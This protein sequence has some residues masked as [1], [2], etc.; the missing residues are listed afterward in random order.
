M[1]AMSP[2][3]HHKP[4]EPPVKQA[5]EIF[6]FQAAKSLLRL[7]TTNWEQ[8]LDVLLNKRVCLVTDE[9]YL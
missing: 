1:W 9:G 7:K 6:H 5:K 4:A 3:P 8:D 2:V